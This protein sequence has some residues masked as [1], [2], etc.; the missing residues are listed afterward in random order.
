MRLVN[1]LIP[2]ENYIEITIAARD[3]LKAGILGKT[4]FFNTVGGFLL[5]DFQVV[6]CLG[7]WTCRSST[8]PLI[9]SRKFR[10]GKVSELL[11]TLEL[12][13]LSI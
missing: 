3:Q 8:A 1:F 9:T 12:V 2:R 5:V 13:A 6:D 10:V 11:I 7:A 4:E